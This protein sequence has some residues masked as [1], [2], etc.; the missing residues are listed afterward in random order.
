MGSQSRFVLFSAIVLVVFAA[1]VLAQGPER[2][3]VLVQL[4]PGTE[5][6]LV[7]A[8]AADQG[9]LVRYEYTILPNVINLRNIPVTALNG[10]RNLPG[11]LR[12]SQDPVIRASLQD[13]TPLIRGLQSQ[14]QNEGLSANGEGI[15]I[16]VPDTGIDSNHWMF[17]D[18][19]DT[20]QTRIDY[21]ASK[22]YINP[23]AFPE[24]DHGHGAHVTGI[25]AGRE[26]LTFNGEPLQGIAPKATIIPV[27]VL[28]SAGQGE[29]SDLIAA[30]QHCTD[31]TLPN[32][33][34]HVISVSLGY[35][36]FSTQAT[37]DAEDVVQAANAAVDAG[38]VVVAAAGNEGSADG[39]AAPG[40][41]SNVISVGGTW[42]Y[43]G[44]DFLYCGLYATVDE[45]LC[46][47]NKSAMLEVVAPG[48]SI[49]SAA[50]D[51]LFNQPNG[52]IE[53]CGTSQAAPHVAGLAALLLDKNPSLTPAQ[54]R[55]K[56]QQGAIDKGP[57]GFDTAYGHGR[58]DVIN[59]LNLAGA[60]APPSVSI[61]NPTEG[62]EVSG[63]VP[64]QIDATDTEDAA[65]TLDVEWNVDGGAWMQAVWNGSSGYYE[66]TWDSTGV[67]D[68]SHTINARA[69]DSASQAGSDTNSVTT[70]NT[71]SAPTV[72]I[73][74]PPDGS[75]FSEGSSITFTGTASDAE[76]GDLSASIAWTSSLD[77][78]LGTGAS[79]SKTLSVGTH[80]ITAS[81]TDSGGATGSDSITVTVNP[82]TGLPTAPTG[83][84]ATGKYQIQGRKQVLQQVELNWQDN[85]NNEDG[86][87]IERWKRSGKGKTKVCAFETTLTMDAAT[88]TGSVT[89]VDTGATTSTCKYRV[90][91]QNS[92]GT[93]AFAET[94]ELNF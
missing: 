73:T 82:S 46:F 44:I 45:V 2:V 16:C 56:I 20:S 4:T 32:G 24:D 74:A 67:E 41:G 92:A 59:S 35:G 39:L 72:T 1:Q 42:D 50:T 17:Q 53:M 48:C 84:T 29:G 60:D 9:G 75:S 58:I 36:P 71:N 30:F 70:E 86:F 80:L 62:A 66:A 63:T 22:N 85:A 94:E 33:P 6:A 3:S 40:C 12:V 5:R 54:V 79:I 90:A 14:I 21:A 23:G 55:E 38:A 11:V 52:V 65:G 88:G 31:P 81:V 7:R 83:L 77:G 78:P 26:G 37:C 49:H 87:V 25:A 13:S 27:K 64:I 10:L 68:G 43:T 47:S 57:A 19:P 89:Y 91:A 69:T 15:R 34:A 28:N 76:D 93:S 18:W 51:L 61:V 8:F